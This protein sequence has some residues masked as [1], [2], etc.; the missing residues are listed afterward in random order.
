M[1][2]II[3]HLLIYDVRGTKGFVI[4]ISKNGRKWKRVV[5]GVLSDAR[6]KG[7]KVPLEEFVFGKKKGRFIRFRAISFYG[8]GAG[9]NYVSWIASM[10]F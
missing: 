5:K 1:S 10:S 3:I 7:C 4:A 8:K 6:N 9:L 2:G